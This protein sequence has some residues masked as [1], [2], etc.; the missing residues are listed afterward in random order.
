[1]PWPNC[2]TPGGQSATRWVR[3]RRD[4]ALHQAQ[5]FHRL[6]LA[7]PPVFAPRLVRVRAW[8]Q[9]ILL[10]K[11]VPSRKETPFF[12]SEQEASLRR[13]LSWTSRL[14]SAGRKRH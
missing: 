1:H 7:Q 10:K 12:L 5:C 9:E 13:L 6:S 8:I 4:R 14:D 3:L 2:R 11:V